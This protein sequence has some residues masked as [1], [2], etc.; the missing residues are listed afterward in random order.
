MCT[1]ISSSQLYSYLNT[2]FVIVQTIITMLRYL[3]GLVLVG[4]VRSQ[5]ILCVMTHCL[6]EF[7]QCSMDP[8]CMTILNCLGG[9]I[10]I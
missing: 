7:T 4:W 8:E 6:T 1:V 3:L 10:T 9:Y 2:I 5:S